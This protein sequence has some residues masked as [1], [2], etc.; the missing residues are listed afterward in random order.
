M[1]PEPLSALPQRAVATADSFTL[2][3]IPMFIFVG[4][5]MTTG[6]MAM[7]LLNFAKALVGHLTGGLA[8]VNV[9]AS[10]LFSGMSG[11]SSAD[12]AGLG[13]VE[14]RLMKQAGYTPRFAAA[15][16][17]A[18]ACIGPLIPPVSPSSSTA[19]WLRFRLGAYSLPVQCRAYC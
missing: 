16:T 12:A 14:I 3:A 13:A 7:R 19:Q 9:A 18:S 10:M 11:S 1:S 5:L 8:Q 15:V 17:G 2:M 4:L 6:P